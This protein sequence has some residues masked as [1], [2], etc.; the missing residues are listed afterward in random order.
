VTLC[1][2]WCVLDVMM[3]DAAELD[4]RPQPAAPSGA[5][6]LRLDEGV[7]LAVLTGIYLCE[8]CSCQ[9][10]LRRNGRGQ[11]LAPLEAAVQ[12]WRRLRADYMPASGGAVVAPLGPTRTGS[13]HAVPGGDTANGSGGPSLGAPSLP[14]VGSDSG[15]AFG[16]DA[17]V[18]WPMEFL[19]PIMLEPMDDPVRTSVGKRR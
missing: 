14:R 12:A 16:T 19:D 6:D 8:V 3:A 18:T 5:A 11:V 9:T 17:D 4:S 1:G 13:Q 10:I 2:V 7:I 15:T